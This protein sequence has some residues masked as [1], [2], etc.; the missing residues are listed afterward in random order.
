MTPS[1]S[2]VSEFRDRIEAHFG[3][4]FDDGR[5]EQVEEALLGRSAA[6]ALS[7]RDY[8]RRLDSL[9]DEWQALAAL[10]TVP[11]SYF[12]RHADHLRV[13]TELVVPA[14]M[15]AHPE[16]RI[17][18]LLSIGCAN[19]EEPYTLSMTLLEQ[20]ELLCD[21]AFTV[22]ACDIN[23]EGLRN[24]QRGL[25]TNWALRATSPAFRSRYFTPAGNRHSIGDHVRQ[26]V[27]FSGCNAL[28]L[29]QSAWAG[30]LDAVFFRNVLI[31][32]SPEAIRAAVNAVAHLLAPGGYLFL[33]PA[34]TLRGISDD[35]TLCH[36]H[37]AFY[38]RRRDSISP[39]I[40]YS[41]LHRPLP[42]HEAAL[43]SLPAVPDEPPAPAS[44]R[45]PLLQAAALDTGWIDEIERSTERVRGLAD[46]RRS[47]QPD[48]A[49]AAPRPIRHSAAEQIQHLLALYVGERYG[50]M[51]A[52]LAA[53]P[54]TVQSDPD[55][56]L[57]RA[58]A[59]L[60]RHELTAAEAAC[61]QIIERDSMNG[62]GHY[63]L[64]LCREQG[65]DFSGAAEHDRIAAYLDASFAMPH[66]HLA[67]MAR[68][69]GDPRTARR[70]FE[71]ANLLLARESASRLMM[72]GGGFSR[73][74]LREI[75]R[76]EL[77][78]LGAA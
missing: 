58:L 6:L 48:Q 42:M 28:D 3:L 70:E 9:E 78:A 62:S 47:R 52:A 43:T 51:M 41:P 63:V 50:E 72:F 21:W 54:G 37:E 4:V 68:R 76:R 49:P 15:A 1:S 31:Y 36:T 13:L 5:R 39:L 65:R 56:Q 40:R 25:Y 8:L 64:A 14:R 59:L 67:L 27:T 18:R 61:G 10:L 74:A 7:V 2:E 44:V 45:F 24:A 23:P 19:G 20:R 33:G 22:H 35:F 32:F 26:H 71:N 46:A 30:T 53:L 77:K 11:E 17:L 69:S 66:L 38:Y 75:C 57:L 16:D 60:N 73:E 12:F 34:E 29:D 55:V